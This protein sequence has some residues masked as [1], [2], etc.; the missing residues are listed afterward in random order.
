[1]NKKQQ[2]FTLIELIIVI[3][4]LGILAVTA[5]PKFLNLQGDANASTLQG[6][7]GSVDSAMRI[8]HG[9]SIIAGT[10][11]IAK[12]NTPA[13]IESVKISYGYPTAAEDGI[14]AALD[15]SVDNTGA[16]LSDF[17]FKVSSTGDVA[18]IY[19]NGSVDPT[20]ATD[21]GTCYVKYTEASSATV[22]AKVEVTS[23]GC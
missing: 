6:V 17:N 22:A 1:M 8:I 19:A 13:D 9:K 21:P 4:I 7:K 23:T 10:Q 18:Y 3:V 15:I 5:S 16:N 11:K 12:A 20:A 2:G 14:I